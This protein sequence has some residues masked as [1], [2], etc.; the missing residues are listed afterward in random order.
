MN[1]AKVISV[2]PAQKTLGSMLEAGLAPGTLGRRILATTSATPRALP[3]AQFLLGVGPKTGKSSSKKMLVIRL[4][5][6]SILIAVALFA[7]TGGMTFP[8]IV[9]LAAGASTIIGFMT[10]PVNT[11]AAVIAA[12][13]AILAAVG[14]AL[15]ETAILSALLYATV[16]IAGPGLFSLD[17]L[18][19]KRP[20]R[21]ERPATRREA[22]SYK[23]YLAG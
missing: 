18:M 16:A 2:N 20:A 6:G 7:S 14:G 1:R 9:A 21:K 3:V 10:R 4:V 13:Q 8:A 19:S 22:M 12:R 11:A 17:A 15:D 23:A 5:V